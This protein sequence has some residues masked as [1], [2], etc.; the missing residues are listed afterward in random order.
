MRCG[1]P[2]FALSDVKLSWS[3]FD[4]AW[5][6]CRQYVFSI[7]FLALV[8]AKCF[9]IFVSFPS[10]LGLS[11]LWSPTFFWTDFLLILGTYVLTRW[12]QWRVVRGLAALI[13]VP[14]R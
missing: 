10:T 7:T 14:L 6:L 8:L 4:R 9:H 5:D 13:T 3:S 11:L 2:S 1:L 12:F